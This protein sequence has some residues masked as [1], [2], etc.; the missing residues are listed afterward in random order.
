MSKI[1]GFLLY[2]LPVLRL[3]LAGLTSIVRGRET[4]DG[5]TWLLP[6][7][8]LD[9]VGLRARDFKDGA[10]FDLVSPVFGSVFC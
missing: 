8:P 9:E 10:L 2:L 7:F 3:P 6:V 1:L 4:A 5:L